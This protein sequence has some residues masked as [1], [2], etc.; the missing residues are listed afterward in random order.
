[1]PDIIVL[2]WPEKTA[3]LMEKGFRRLTRV[4]ALDHV[5]ADGAATLPAEW[6]EEAD[7]V[8]VLVGSRVLFRTVT[9]EG[10]AGAELLEAAKFSAEPTLPMPLT[11]LAVTAFEAEKRG[12]SR[13]IIVGAI[14]RGA[15][16]EITAWARLLTVDAN[17]ENKASVPMTWI[18]PT[19]AA[20][21]PDGRDAV[22]GAG[23]AG[24]AESGRWKAVQSAK[25][26]R[27]AADEIGRGLD[28]VPEWKD[29][30]PAREYEAAAR[31]N[32][33]GSWQTGAMPATR[34]RKILAGWPLAMAGAALLVLTVSFGLRAV[35]AHQRVAAA[36]A[37][38]NESFARALPG[39]RASSPRE[40]LRSRIREA[41]ALDDAM[42]DRIAKKGS[43]MDVLAAV[44]KSAPPGMAVIND[45]RITQKGFTIMGSATD[46]ALV[47]SLAQALTSLPTGE[48]IRV[49]EP[50]IRRTGAGLGLDFTLKGER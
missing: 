49:D 41:H 11:D 35:A 9:L 50:E 38:I 1:M 34:A 36:E 26:G 44:E 45:L 15:L 20:M 46:I 27:E 33:S 5:G 29:A 6:I 21:K 22:I 10:A 40:Q 14:P 18:G 39:V 32:V 43:A 3:A 13:R 31:A 47:Q 30:D 4:A 7:E 8:R 28:P 23:W 25:S 48:A 42:R 37:L 2:R 19:A 12:R 24:L 16:D 17:S